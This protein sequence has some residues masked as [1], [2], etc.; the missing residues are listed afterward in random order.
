MGIRVAIG[1]FATFSAAI[2]SQYLDNE[3]KKRAP[4][5]A[6]VVLH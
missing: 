4:V 3:A 2:A 5:K 6:A 1:V